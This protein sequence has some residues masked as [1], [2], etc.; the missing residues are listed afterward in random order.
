MRVI[1]ESGCGK[2]HSVPMLVGKR[3]AGDN[4][5]GRDDPCRA[6]SCGGG[7]CLFDK[8]AVSCEVARDRRK[9]EQRDA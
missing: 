7:D 8:P 9:M 6:E 5:F 4:E 2:I 3:I 1:H